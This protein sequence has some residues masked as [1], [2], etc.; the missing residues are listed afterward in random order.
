M[1]STAA[2]VPVASAS[3]SAAKPPKVSAPP[4]C[5]GQLPP[6]QLVKDNFAST[7]LSGIAEIVASSASG[8]DGSHPAPA[9]GYVNF[10]YEVRVVKWFA[11]SG[12]ERLVLS[13]GAEAPGTPRPP[14]DLL[15]FS[16]C[17]S[18][19][20]TAYEPDVGYFFPVDPSCR[21]DAEALGDAARSKVKTPSRKIPAACKP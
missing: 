3:S 4:S 12:P 11:G 19:V 14:G 1:A 20:G 8:T 2:P 16:A 17:T 21:A 6:L 15:F 13:Q 5:G 10:R 18:G 9:T 7:G